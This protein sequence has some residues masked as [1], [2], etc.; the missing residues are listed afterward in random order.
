MSHLQIE[1]KVSSKTIHF[2]RKT[3]TLGFFK[4]CKNAGIPCTIVEN[5]KKRC[6]SKYMPKSGLVLQKNE[7]NSETIKDCLFHK[8]KLERVVTV[9]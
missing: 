8:T 2:P 7:N 4:I 5:K 6:D 9:D 3:K 1:E